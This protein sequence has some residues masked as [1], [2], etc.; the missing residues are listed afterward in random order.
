MHT[1]RC[2]G[3]QDKA[4][5]VFRKPDPKSW[6]R[7]CLRLIL[8]LAADSSSSTIKS[9]RCRWGKASGLDADDD[10]ANVGGVWDSGEVGQCVS[11]DACNE[12]HLNSSACIAFGC[13]VRQIQ[14]TQSGG[15]PALPNSTAEDG[16]DVPTPGGAFGS[17]QICAKSG[18]IAAGY[19]LSCD[20]FLSASTCEGTY[21][22]PELL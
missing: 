13:E 16:S 5:H 8:S 6:F 12:F 3:R 4:S 15:P 18:S 2:V 22:F 11:S 14:L 17:R 9:R 20:E 19:V 1:V 7:T 21:T 10:G